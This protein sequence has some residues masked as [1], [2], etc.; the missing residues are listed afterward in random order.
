MR[1]VISLEIGL[2]AN[3]CIHIHDKKATALFDVNRQSFPLSNYQ[4][5]D[6]SQQNAISV[7]FTKFTTTN[8]IR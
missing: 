1:R 6:R 7:K 3:T 8:R 2:A 4:Q 5:G